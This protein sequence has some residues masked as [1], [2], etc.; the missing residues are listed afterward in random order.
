MKE[1][2]ANAKKNAACT[3]EEKISLLDSRAENLF[4]KGRF[5]DAGKLYTQACELARQP[6]V[7][8]YFLGQVGICHYN[9]G[10][11]KQALQFLL[12]SARLFRPDQPE[13]MT[14][15]YGYIHFHLGS[16]FEY[17]GKV[18]K[19][20]EARKICERYV[21]AQE[22]DTQWMLYAGISRNY[23]LLGKHDEAIRYSQ[24]AIQVL[25]DNDPGL[26]YLYESMGNNYLGLKQYHEA[27]KYFTKVME[28]DPE[29]ERRDEV[30]LK[31]ANS[32]QQLTNDQMA[33]ETYEKMLE[34][35][36]LTEKR[37]NL[38][39]LY[40]KIAQC[41]FRLERYEKSLLVTLEA[42]RRR[43]RNQLEKAEVRSYLTNNYYELGRYRDAVAEGEKTIAIAKKFANDCQFYFR[44][45]LS[46]FKLGDKRSFNKYRNLCRKRPCDS[47]WI[48]YLDKLT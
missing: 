6:N 35:K 46:Y 11:D 19:A 30:H 33:L 25:S 38:G 27:I 23:E 13:F 42:L 1:R 29:F 31:V 9:A 12:K 48:A 8:A 37:E 5:A 45:A 21:D 15:M 47:S 22:K 4:E 16:L 14:D 43:P 2:K 39:W 3:V 20:L 41:Q 10:D 36:Q 26:A 34:I 40:L 17:H 44:M 32:Y 7:R 24:K 28:L 18:S